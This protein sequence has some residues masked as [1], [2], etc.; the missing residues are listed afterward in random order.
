ML[1]YLKWSMCKLISENKDLYSKNKFLIDRNNYI[2]QTVCQTS[3]NIDY[4]VVLLTK[5]SP[6]GLEISNSKIE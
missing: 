5:L 3:I 4:R 1:N 2:C 6:I